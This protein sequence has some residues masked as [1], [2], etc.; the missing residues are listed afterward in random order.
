ML[1]PETL[2]ELFCI[3]QKIKKTDKLI[4]WIG[5]PKENYYQKGSTYI[6]DS[7][8]VSY[9]YDNFLCD[10]LDF[11]TFSQTCFEIF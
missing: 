8:S 1:T 6:L 3:C 11:R 10:K 7:K 2:D 4:E 5:T 9:I